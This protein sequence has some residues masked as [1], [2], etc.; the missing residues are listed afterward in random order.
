MVGIKNPRGSALLVVLALILLASAAAMVTLDAANTEIELSYNQIHE[1]QAFYVAESGAIRAFSTLNVDSAWRAGYTDVSFSE[2]VYTVTLRDSTSDSSLV[3][4]VLVQS[5]ASVDGCRSTVELTLVPDLINPFTYA[6]FAK[7]F[8]DIKN[9]FVT[10]SYNSDSGSYAATQLW[11]GGDVGSNSNISVNT[12]AVIGG[13]VSTALL[14]GADVNPGATVTGTISDTAPEQDIPTISDEEFDWAESVSAAGPGISGTYSYNSSTKVLQATG[15]FTLGSGV[16]YFSSITLMNSASLQI[17]PG[18]E[19]TI[20]VSGDIEMKNS[21]EVNVGGNAA[22]VFI[23]SRG[24]LYL[25]NSGDISAVFYNPDGVADL[26]NSGEFTGSIVANDI[27][28]HNSANFHYDRMLA[29][30]QRKGRDNYDMVAWGE[31][32]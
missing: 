2:G 13:D 24:D 10:D 28:C 15:P 12:G 17:A 23:Y 29:K 21:S 25:K 27:I 9:S 1:E 5:T 26:R 11:D 18:A 16:Y 3:D 14:G 8:V 32:L 19:V 20:Y 7:N 6:M 31:L 4:T 30:I 22:D